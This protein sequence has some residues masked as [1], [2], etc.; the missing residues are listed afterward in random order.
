M[1]F[2]NL[3]GR[4]AAMLA[5]VVV[6]AVL[7]LGWFVLL[8]P[9]RSKVTRLDDQIS[10][11]QA[12][13]ASTQAYV[14]DPQTKRAAQELDRLKAMIPDDVRM[15]QV[16]RQLSAAATAAG[17]QID[18]IQPAL[19][20][21]VGTAEA[22]PI[23]L[24][25]EGHYFGLASFMRIL[26]SQVRIQDSKVV[27]HGRLYSVGGIQFTGGGTASGG[28]NVIT[29]VISLNAFVNAPAPLTTTAPTT[30]SP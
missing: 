10:S 22:A 20:V 24:S 16:L 11:T 1:T 12:Q 2:A 27:G 17:V 29:A 15:P 5:T 9:Q 6:L 28:Q 13:I 7:L 3:S 25:V 21:G 26:R 18:N 30:T 4:L 14:A 23:Q 8:A 19:P